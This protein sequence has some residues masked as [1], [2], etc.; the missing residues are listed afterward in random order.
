MENLAFIV[1]GVCFWGFVIY[2]LIKGS[3]IE[4]E[5]SRNRYN[6]ISI[7]TVVICAIILVILDYSLTNLIYIIVIALGYILYT[8]IPSGYNNEAIFIKGKKM[9]YCK[10]EDLKKEYFNGICRLNIKYGFRFYYLDEKIENKILL[11]NCEQLYKREKR[12]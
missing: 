3:K 1:V 4:V 8:C 6:V 5:V 9:P 11:E 10:I 12:R 2:R 7:I